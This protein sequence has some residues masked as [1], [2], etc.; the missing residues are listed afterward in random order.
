MGK[1]PLILIVF[2]SCISSKKYYGNSISP[3]DQQVELDSILIESSSRGFYEKLRISNDSIYFEKKRPD[4]KFAKP[5]STAKWENLE[6]LVE[7]IPIVE[8][9]K[10]I[11]PSKYYQF[12]GS[13]MTNLA[14]YINGNEIKSQTFDKDNPPKQFKETLNFISN[15]K[16]T[17]LDH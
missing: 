11:P 7:Q 4:F 2:A 14:V 8:I 10:V 9:T 16:N 6:S 5:I 3:I 13:A 17:Y 15:L 12:D 1:L